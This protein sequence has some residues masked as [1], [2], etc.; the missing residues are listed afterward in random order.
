L[1]K[2]PG[3]WRVFPTYHEL[4]SAESA[5]ADT[6]VAGPHL[7]SHVLTKPTTAEGRTRINVTECSIGQ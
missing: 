1:L 7:L 3:K 6:K 5:S 4:A 2:L